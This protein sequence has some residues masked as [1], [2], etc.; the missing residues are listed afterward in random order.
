MRARLAGCT[1]S[2]TL[3]VPR[4]TLILLPS[5]RHPRRLALPGFPLARRR[6]KEFIDS[7]TT[8]TSKA[9]ERAAEKPPKSKAAVSGG[10]GGGGRASAGG[11]DDWLVGVA[12]PTGKFKAAGGEK[13]KKKKDKGK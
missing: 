11:D 1:L 13:K 4:C 5:Q 2:L 10:C 7:A 12:V 3:L 8:A 9:A 6:A